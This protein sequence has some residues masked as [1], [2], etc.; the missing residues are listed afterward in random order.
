MDIAVN[1]QLLQRTRKGHTPALFSHKQRLI[2]V[3]TVQ[4]VVSLGLPMN[5]TKLL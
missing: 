4:L 1:L 3:N 2:L 5:N